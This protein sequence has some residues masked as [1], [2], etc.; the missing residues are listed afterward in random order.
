[1]R[2]SWVSRG[3][4]NATARLQGFTKE[5][6]MSRIQ[7]IHWNA[8]EAKERAERIKAAG[9]EVSYEVPNGMAFFHKWRDDLPRAVVIDL[10][11]LPMQGR[12]AALAIRHD[13]TT[14]HIP[15]VFVE[16]EAEKV[17]R[18]KEK[19]PDAVYAAWSQVKSASQKAIAHPPQEPIVPKSLLDG[20]SGQPLIKKL[21]IKP[22][23]VVALV[24]APSDFKKIPV[25]PRQ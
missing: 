22:D 14:R 1:V 20:Y 25:K 13:K 10:T 24:D 3:N 23:A 7:L 8:N 12:D 11:R 18:V 17:E 6:N 4:P 2:I 16:G 9:Y 21:G 19:I 5:Q 15:I